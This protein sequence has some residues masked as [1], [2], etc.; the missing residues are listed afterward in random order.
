MMGGAKSH[1]QR[2][3][4]ETN[5]L[6]PMLN[7]M[8]KRE[9][10]DAHWM[11]GRRDGGITKTRIYWKDERAVGYY[12]YSL[13]P[14]N[15]RPCPVLGQLYVRPEERR[16]GYATEMLRDY[17]NILPV[18]KYPHIGIESPNKLAWNLQDSDF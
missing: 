7:H 4:S 5:T 3:K 11:S 16:K 14:K 9:E 13:P 1:I 6:L 10:H 15:H 18:E 12:Y 2:N 17:Q 8:A